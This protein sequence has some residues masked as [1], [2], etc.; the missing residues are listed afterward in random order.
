MSHERPSDIIRILSL[1]QTHHLVIGVSRA[2][3]PSAPDLRDLVAFHQS[4]RYQYVSQ[5]FSHLSRSTSRSPNQLLDLL[6]TLMH[7]P[8]RIVCLDYFS[9]VTYNTY[10]HNWLHR[11]GPRLTHPPTH[12]EGNCAQ[13]LQF[14]T[15]VYLPNDNRGDLRRMVNRYRSYIQQ[16][17]LHLRLTHSSPLATNDLPLGPIAGRPSASAQIT[18]YLANPPFLRVLPLHAP[19]DP[20]RPPDPTP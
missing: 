12:L 8:S 20:I 5:D 2:P 15:E 13:L 7:I 18:Q 1:L 4:G 11:H 17:T 16:P 19:P 10:G 6:S 3:P 9:C 14:A